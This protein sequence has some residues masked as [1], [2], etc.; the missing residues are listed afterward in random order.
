MQPNFTDIQPVFPC[1]DQ[2]AK[3]GKPGLV[4]ESGKRFSGNRFVHKGNLE[5]SAA[6]LK[7]DA[8]EIPKAAKRL[9]TVLFS[10]VISSFTDPLL[11]SRL[12][13]TGN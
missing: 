13:S 3:D 4:T 1:P 9:Y 6:R 7:R 2:Q 12:I 10:H 5:Q 8:D 11:Q